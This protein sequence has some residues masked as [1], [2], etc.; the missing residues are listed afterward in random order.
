MTSATAKSHDPAV[1]PVA[2]GSEIYPPNPAYGKGIYRRRIRLR[3]QALSVLAMVD[4]THHAMWCRIHHDG[5]RI[6]GIEAAFNRVPTSTCF[7]AGQPLRELI[8]LPLDIGRRELYG[9]GRPQRNCTHQ[10]DAAALALTHARRPEADL[11]FDVVVPDETD[12]PVAAQ[13]LRNGS[14]ILQWRIQEAQILLEGLPPA[15]LMRGFAAWAFGRF[16]GEELE[17]AFVLQRGYFVSRARRVLADAPLGLRNR[18]NPGLAGV[19]HSYIEPQWAVGV[20][21]TNH[22]RDFTAALIEDPEPTSPSP[23]R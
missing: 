6:T 15:P 20:K 2:D 18:D 12:E 5:A 4:D 13:V 11:V 9:G 3:R 21:L 14:P 7:S 19:C 10:F 22:V 1:A 23:V 8:G 16:E 17:A